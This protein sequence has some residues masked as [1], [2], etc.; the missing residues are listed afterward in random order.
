[1][2]FDIFFQPCRFKGLAVEKKNLFTGEVQPVLANEPFVFRRGR[3]SA[4]LQEVSACTEVA[5]TPAL[6]RGWFEMP[7]RTTPDHAVH[8]W[9]HGQRAHGR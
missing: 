7:A 1:M 5:I 2:S 6:R 9:R 4:T 3:P 8:R